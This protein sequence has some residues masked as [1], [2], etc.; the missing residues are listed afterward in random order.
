[1]FTQEKNLLHHTP[2]SKKCVL[3]FGWVGATQRN[4]SVYAR[5]YQ[6]L[7][8]STVVAIAN[9]WNAMMYNRP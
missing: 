8:F 5:L 6:S 2:N 3:L 1:M 4:V 9:K 7:G